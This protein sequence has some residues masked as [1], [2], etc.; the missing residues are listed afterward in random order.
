MPTGSAAYYTCVFCWVS[1]IWWIKMTLDLGNI[2]LFEN[3]IDEYR[4]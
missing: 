3:I 4:F 2:T 1:S